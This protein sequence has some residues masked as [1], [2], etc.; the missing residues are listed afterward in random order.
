MTGR[1]CEREGGRRMT[2]TNSS[3]G[4]LHCE[5]RTSRRTRK[6]AVP[7]TTCLA[8]LGRRRRTTIEDG[9]KDRVDR[10]G[11]IA[12]DGNRGEV[13]EEGRKVVVERMP[14]SKDR[15]WR[16]AKGEDTGRECGIAMVVAE[17]EESGE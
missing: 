12:N 5:R 16:F 9:R 14:S 15:P 7:T 11:R 1:G 6:S 2:G 8:V 17:A 10:N 4:E 3:A 13:V